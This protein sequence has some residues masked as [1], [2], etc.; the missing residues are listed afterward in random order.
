[1]MNRSK[2]D[3]CDFSWNPIT[4]CRHDCTYCYARKQSRRFCGDVR[5]NKASSQLQKQDDLWILEESFKNINNKV[6]PL[7]V[8]FEPTLHRYRMSMPQEKKLPANIF[9]GSMAD[10]FGE[11]VPD[12]WIAEVF[13]ACNAAP[14][15]NYLFLT[16]NPKGMP[17]NSFIY[18]G[19]TDKHSDNYWFGMSATNQESLER[20][21]KH[22]TNIHGN[23]FLSIEPLHEPINLSHIDTGNVIYNITKS[24]GYYVGSGRNVQ[25]PK[26]V[27][28]GAETGSRKGKVIPKREWIAEIVDH[29]QSAAVPVFMKDNLK[30]V[31]GENLLQE[32]P[33]QLI[34][35]SWIN[36][37]VHKVFVESVR[38]KKK[39]RQCGESVRGKQAMRISARFYICMKCYEG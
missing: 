14:W 19:T 23:T 17:L 39:C 34:T 35:P 16:K 1:M 11:W 18:T 26:W 4:G 3:W 7:P 36:R 28:I 5:L 20:G 8:G 25:N 29:C 15:H 31:W 9:V 33:R 21:Y 32:F 13:E 10:V 22:F 37:P 12:E 24:M 30:N 27:I 6:I 38:D 2:I